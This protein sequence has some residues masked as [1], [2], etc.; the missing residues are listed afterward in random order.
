MRKFTSL[1]T[2]FLLLVL[3]LTVL[4]SCKVK[5]VEPNGAYVG[6]DYYPLEQGRYIIYDVYDTTYNGVERIDTLYQ[7]KEL[8]YS[9][10]QE[11]EEV[12]YVLHQYYKKTTD[13]DWKEQPDSVWSLVNSS[14]QLIRTENNIPYIKLVFPV[15]ENK[16]WD[17]NAKNV[18][19]SETYTMKNVD[20]SYAVSNLDFSQTLTVE[21]SNVKNVISKD[22][23]YEIYARGVGAVKKEYTV[24]SYDQ[25]AIGSDI[26]EYGYHKV[27]VVTSYGQE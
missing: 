16:K 4:Y 12:K 17:G 5:N 11:G 6:Y 18:Y 9:S 1:R 10:F 8:V 19:D 2:C 15:E 26:I 27:F 21:M 22:S 3:F 25:S 14:N 23:R 7:L 13:A 24:Y 20:D